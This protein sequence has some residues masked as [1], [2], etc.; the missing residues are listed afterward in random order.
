MSQER[1]VYVIDDDDAVRASICML[2]ES[3]GVPARTY[4]SGGAFLRDL[5]PTH[6]CL[7]VD[8][9]MPGMSGL[10]LL[11][12][13]RGRGSAI[14]AIVMTGALTAGIRG[15]ADRAGATLLRKPFRPGELITCIEKALG[16]CRA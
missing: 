8:A 16:S 3:Y 1:I 4:P 11:D 13:L 9:N 5:P 14:P 15:A 2:L 6:G 12:Q 7:L 10:E